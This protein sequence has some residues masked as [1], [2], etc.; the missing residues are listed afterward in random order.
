M[1][2]LP[3]AMA[4]VWNVLSDPGVSSATAIFA[5][6]VAALAFFYG[7]YK[8]H[9]TRLQRDANRL[10]AILLHI[11]QILLRYDRAVLWARG[12]GVTA[13]VYE[14]CHD[15]IQPQLAAELQAQSQQLSDCLQLLSREQPVDYVL[16]CQRL[17]QLRV[18]MFGETPSTEK[19]PEVIYA[20]LVRTQ[21]LLVSDFIADIAKLLHGR[22]ARPI[23]SRFLLR[24]EERR[25]LE[26]LSKKEDQDRDFVEGMRQQRRTR[27]IVWHVQD[28]LKEIAT[29]HTDADFERALPALLADWKSAQRYGTSLGDFVH[30]YVRMLQSEYGVD[31]EH[32][33]KIGRRLFRELGDDSLGTDNSGTQRPDSAAPN[34]TQQ[35]V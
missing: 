32:S 4:G 35:T 14:A 30:G 11:Y 5:A 31:V 20:D 28:L 6:L 10:N 16:L 33:E 24:R 26:Y 18:A 7:S 13:E 8:T 34:A 9:R 3:E 1:F 29:I 27:S 23:Y 22:I 17:A 21:D 15:R 25:I 2:G 19:C 12:D